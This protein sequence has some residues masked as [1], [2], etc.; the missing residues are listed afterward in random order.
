MLDS[1]VRTVVPFLAGVLIS[2]AARAGLDLPAGPVGEVLTGVFGAVYY[3][4]ARALERRWAVAG[5]VLLGAGV[6]RRVPRYE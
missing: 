4:V 2:L 1:V 5:R 6:V 3:V